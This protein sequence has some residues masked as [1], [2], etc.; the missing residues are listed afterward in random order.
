M[1]VRYNY[2]VVSDN[3]S[4]RLQIWPEHS[5]GPSEQKPIKNLEKREHGRI[6]G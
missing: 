2:I 6:Q 4:Y 5:Y 1:L 3:I